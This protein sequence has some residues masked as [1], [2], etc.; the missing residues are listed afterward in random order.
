MKYSVVLGLS[1][2]RASGLSASWADAVRHRQQTRPKTS[3]IGRC[4]GMAFSPLAVDILARGTKSRSLPRP[5]YDRSFVAD[6]KRLRP[7]GGI[8]HRVNSLFGSVA[9]SDFG[10]QTLPDLVGKKPS[11]RAGNAGR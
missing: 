3:T 9:R 5:V 11:L 1:R 7:Q 10:D 8:H 2:R 6:R 4:R